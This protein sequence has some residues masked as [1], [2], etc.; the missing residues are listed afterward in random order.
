MR[1]AIGCRTCGLDI[2]RLVA[3]YPDSKIASLLKQVLMQGFHGTCSASLDL[4]WNH[5]RAD[6]HEKIN[7]CIRPGPHSFPM[8]QR[9]VDVLRFGAFQVFC[10]ELFAKAPALRHEPTVDW[11]PDR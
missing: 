9:M 3:V 2:R 10:H 5:M 8:M 11:Q 7:L 6:L 1:P 4:D